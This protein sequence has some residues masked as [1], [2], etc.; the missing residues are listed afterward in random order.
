MFGLVF[1]Q[2]QNR[3]PSDLS[4][5][6]DFGFV[7]KCHVIPAIDFNGQ[8]RMFL[9]VFLPGKVDCNQIEIIEVGLR[10]DLCRPISVWPG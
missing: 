10:A 3:R 6:A 8:R 2:Q 1:S 7:E 4:V 5:N 9:F